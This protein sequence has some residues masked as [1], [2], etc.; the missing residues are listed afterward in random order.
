MFDVLTNGNRDT[1][2]IITEV[3]KRGPFRITVTERGELDSMKSATLTSKVEGSTTIISIVPEGT[4]VTEGQIVCELDSSTLREE[5]TQQEI[6]VTQAEA[7]LE[8]ARKN[9]EIQETQNES[10]V[11]AATLAEELAKLDLRKFREGEYNQQVNELNGK[12]KTFEEELTRARENYEFTK[13]LAK[14]GYKSQNDVEA[15]RIAVLKAEINLDV[16]KEKLKVLQD[17]T[18]QRTIAELQENAIESERERRRVELSGDA[19]LAQYKAEVQ[20][21]KLT[22]E[23]EK[24]ELE[25]LREQIEACTLRAPQDGEVVYPSESRRRSEPQ[26]IEAG[27]TVRERQ[28]IIKLP[29]LTQMK[30]DANIHESRIS[31][32]RKGL[33]VLI[34][35]DARSDEL[36][37]GV[38]DSVSSV[39]MSTNW[40]RPEL[41]EYEAVVRITDDV[42]QVKGLKP[43]LTASIEIVVNE[44]PDVLQVPVQ[45]VVTVGPKRYAF[46]ITEADVERREILIGESN[47]KSIEVLDGLKEGERV[48]M[49]PR[50]YFADELTELEAQ[51]SATKPDDNPNEADSQDLPANASGPPAGNDVSPTPQNATDEQ[52]GS[53]AGERTQNSDAGGSAESP[54]RARGTRD[55]AAFLERLDSDG[56]GKL[57][58]EE[59][60]E[61]MRSFFAT[62]DANQDGSL[63][64]EELRKFSDMMR[65]RGRG[66]QRP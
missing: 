22:Y 23:V 34:R 66:G 30:V 26:V 20:A 42:E 24:K 60:P 65:D 9:V 45:A 62:L 16:E 6:K 63:G 58:P 2:E 40:M 55:P 56:D 19:A 15:A 33:P 3:S 27:S 8:K 54:E 37:H 53:A 25:R 21:R 29:D 61:R 28:T 38:V 48:A 64:A 10:D 11:A 49:N 47:D 59:V 7:D 5:A 39:P 1:S 46:V 51:F 32:I 50:T 31:L 44:R 36:F 14:K 35:V 18:Y 17:Y 43:G 41:K 13:R 57:S 4:L 52:R 12:I